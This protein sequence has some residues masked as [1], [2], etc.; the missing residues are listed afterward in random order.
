MTSMVARP[1]F[2]SSKT[3]PIVTIDAVGA[4]FCVF[5]HEDEGLPL[6]KLDAVLEVK[7]EPWLRLEVALVVRGTFIMASHIRE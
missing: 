1:K 3:I 6:I 4:C 7:N 2:A 5:F